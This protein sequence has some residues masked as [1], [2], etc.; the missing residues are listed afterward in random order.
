MYSIAI[1][2]AQDFEASFAWAPPSLVMQ[3]TFLEVQRVSRPTTLPLNL[4]QGLKKIQRIEVLL[5]L[6]SWI[7]SN[8]E[9]YLWRDGL[10]C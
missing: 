9:G 8:S 3:M 5:I 4:W 6:A 7:K 2:I 1:E 10:H